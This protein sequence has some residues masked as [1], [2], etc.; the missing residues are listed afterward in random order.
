MADNICV[1]GTFQ[2]TKNAEFDNKEKRELQWTGHV[3][4]Y[5][6]VIH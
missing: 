1:V 2:T 5:H 3:G 4:M 6:P